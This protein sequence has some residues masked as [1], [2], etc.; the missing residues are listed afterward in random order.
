MTGLGAN[1]SSVQEGAVTGLGSNS[2]SVQEG[3]VTGLGANRRSVQ[4]GC[5]CTVFCRTK[6]SGHEPRSNLHIVLRL[7]EVI[8]PPPHTFV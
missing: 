6:Q 5:G 3:A 4:T 2:S 8:P 1:S 7:D